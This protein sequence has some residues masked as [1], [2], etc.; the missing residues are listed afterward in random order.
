MSNEDVYVYD[1]M[2]AISDVLKSLAPSM[3]EEVRGDL[4]AEIAFHLDK[5]HML[6]GGYRRGSY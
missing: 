4:A 3:D 5:H 2:A 1:A 6:L